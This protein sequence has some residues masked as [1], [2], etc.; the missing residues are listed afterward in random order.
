[1]A[2]IYIRTTREATPVLYREDEEFII[3]GSK[4]LRKSDRDRITVIGAGVTVHEALKAYEELKKEGIFIRVI[5]LYC[6]KPMDET[7][8]REA[9]KSDAIDHHRGRPL[10]GRRNRRSGRERSGYLSPSLSILWPCERSQ[11]VVNPKNFSM[12]RRSPRRPSF[13]RLKELL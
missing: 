12:M 5:D 3:G 9:A 11:G 4:V 10:C 8:L 7:T 2:S 1:M 6:I 13:G